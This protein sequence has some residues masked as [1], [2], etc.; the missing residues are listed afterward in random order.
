MNK[1]IIV[2][3]FLAVIC[4]AIAA[5]LAIFTSI[6]VFFLENE[7]ILNLVKVYAIFVGLFICSAVISMLIPYKEETEDPYESHNGFPNERW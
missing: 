5:L 4:L 3:R 6:G 7:V 2:S 1:V